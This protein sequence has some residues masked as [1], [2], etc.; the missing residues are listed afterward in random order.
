MRGR[1]GQSY[2]LPM[3]QPAKTT[4]FRVY[5]TPVPNGRE[6]YT[7]AEDDTYLYELLPMSFNCRLVI[8][9]KDSPLTYEY[10]WCYSSAV[11]VRAA[12]Q[13]WDPETQ[14]EPLGWHKRA[15]LPRVAPRAEED[16]H[17]NRPRCAHGRYPADGPCG[18]D[19][20]CGGVPVR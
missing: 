2:G 15:L 5:D 13:V 10:G 7:L 1:L 17:H 14:N 11:G 8:T 16:P 4:S 6:G 9:P 20:F 18:I 3:T 19:Q 12:V